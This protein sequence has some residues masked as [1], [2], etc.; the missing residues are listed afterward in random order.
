MRHPVI[1]SQNKVEKILKGSLNSISS[2]SPSLKIQ[3]MDR[4]FAYGVKAKH[5]LAM[6]T[7]LLFSKVCFAL[8]LQ[9]NFPA[10]NLNFQ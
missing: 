1:C 9:A 6:S 7:N 4:K 10:H 8:T 2:P 5:C 3:I